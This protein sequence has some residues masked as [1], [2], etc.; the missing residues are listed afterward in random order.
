MAESFSYM[1]HYEGIAEQAP[2]EFHFETFMPKKYVITNDDSAEQKLYFKFNGE[3]M[4]SM[5]RGGESI[6]ILFRSHS[7]YLKGN[8]VLYRVMIFG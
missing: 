2:T 4:Y 7:L 5:L 1:E 6:S 8:T 3:T